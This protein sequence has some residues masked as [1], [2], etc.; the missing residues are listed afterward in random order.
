MGP[1]SPDEMENQIQEVRG[2]Q[3]SRYPGY[4]DFNIP[5]SFSIR[6]NFNYSKPGLTS[7][8]TQTLSFSGNISLTPKWKIGVSSGWDFEKNALAYTSLNIYRDL[9]CWEMRFSWVP[10]GYRQSYT[11]GINAK[12]S[13]LKDLKYE[14]N[15]N[16]RDF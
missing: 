6:Y 3:S 14:R 2:E 7:K 1:G 11:F 12:A 4:V 16:W 9:H 5:W 10:I 13:I 8:V 15:K